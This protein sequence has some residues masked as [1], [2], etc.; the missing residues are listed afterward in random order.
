VT[1]CTFKTKRA[2]L[3][4]PAHSFLFVR[5]PTMESG[6]LAEWYVEEG[7]GF[8]A[9]D[10]IAKI[11]TDKASIDFEAQDDG[12]VAKILLPTGTDASQDVPVGTP[13]MITVEE[14]E[15]VRAFKDYVH[16]ELVAAPAPAPAASGPAEA[17]ATA[18]VAAEP[19]PAIAVESSSPLPV[20]SAATAPP[21]QPPPPSPPQPAAP[22]AAATAA[23]AWGMS[24]RTSSPL[25]KSLSNRQKAYVEKYGSTGQLPL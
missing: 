14:E 23:I 17:E 13:I 20:P 7:A 6:S 16:P 25:S 3:F 10:A 11:E 24:A 8:T 19:E 15:H 9:G 21:P 2:S 5:S 12:Y 1:T 22:A 4:F 18:A